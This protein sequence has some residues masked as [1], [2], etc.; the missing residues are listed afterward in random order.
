MQQIYLDNNATTKMLP[1]VAEVIVEAHRAGY[2]NPASQHQSGQRARRVLEDARERITQLLGGQTTGLHPDRLL[3]TSG[4]TESNNLALRGLTTGVRDANIVI[5]PL[6]HP[7]ISETALQLSRSGIAVRRLQVDRNGVVQTAELD[8]L[9]D[10]RTRVVSVMLGNHE[11]GVLQPV[12][13][14]ADIARK[15]GVPMHCDGVQAVGKIPVDFRALGVDALSVSPHKLHGPVG[16]GGLLLRHDVALAPLMAGGFQQQGIRPGT[17]SI[18]LT[19]GFLKALELWAEQATESERQMR[20][21]RDML[22]D[23]LRAEIPSVIINGCGADRL[24]HT[25]NISFP[26]LNRQAFVLALD[27]AGVACSTGSACASGSSEPS[28]VLIAMGLEPPVVE[29]SIRISLSRST[30]ASDIERA[31]LHILRVYKALQQS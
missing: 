17:E 4:G 23:R 21:L 24:P 26:G 19:L 14:V 5:S 28:P 7:S 31:S 9:L 3:I 16:I 25:S 1:E 13:T 22:E 11:T 10:E 12:E 18:A 27:M 30:T 29:G 2:A 8:R 20:T 15:R 6:E